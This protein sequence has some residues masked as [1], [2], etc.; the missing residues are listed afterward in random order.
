MGAV[1]YPDATVA[2]LLNEK[3]IAVQVNIDK[4]PKLAE[5]FQAI[6]T[7]NLN[8]V[9]QKE[10]VLYHIEGW[11]S[12]SECAAMLTIAQGHYELHRKKFDQAAS[13][14]KAVFDRYPQSEVA[15]EAL[16]YLGDSRYLA[17]HEVEHLIEGW[18]D[19]RRYYPSSAWAR[20]SMVS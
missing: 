12:P 1:T 3:F 8:I 16:Y 9:N 18:R 6:W 5:K 19:C 11:L 2:E 4:V 13:H 10:K 20:R 14:F 17:S 7:P 15:L